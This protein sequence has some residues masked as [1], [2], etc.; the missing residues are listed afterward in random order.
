ML[1]TPSHLLLPHTR[2]QNTFLWGYTK[3]S[4]NKSDVYQMAPRIKHLPNGASDPTFTKWRHGSNIHKIVPLIPQWPDMLFIPVLACLCKE[5]YKR[6]NLECSSWKRRTE[7]K[8]MRQPEDK[9]LCKKQSRGKEELKHHRRTYLVE[10]PSFVLIAM[11]R[12][13]ECRIFHSRKM[14]DLEKTLQ[15]EAV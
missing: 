7:R 1:S 14:K 5:I 12:D 15:T 3:R 8:I 13:L 10:G 11:W 6:R 9:T 2:P 4:W